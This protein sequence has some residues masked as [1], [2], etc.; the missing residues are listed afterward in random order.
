MTETL[1]QLGMGGIL[2]LLVLREVFGFL[3][4]RRL[5]G[6]AI[7]GPPRR[8]GNDK[9]TSVQA[10]V[11]AALA[12]LGR[13]IERLDDIAA[14]TK[15]A[16]KQSEITGEQAERIARHLERLGDILDKIDSSTR[17]RQTGASPAIT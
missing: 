1:T 11:D 16:R 12:Q 10:S 17:R 8:P 4:K 13:I 6:S 14:A 9:V 2:V 3:A 15:A 5:N 7:G